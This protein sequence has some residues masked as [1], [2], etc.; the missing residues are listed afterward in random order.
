MGYDSSYSEWV[1]SD[2]IS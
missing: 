2:E 1:D